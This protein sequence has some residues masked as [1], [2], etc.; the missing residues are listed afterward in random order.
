[1]F[2]RPK[3]SKAKQHA[4][5][6]LIKNYEIARYGIEKIYEKYP[7]GGLNRVDTHESFASKQK[8]DVYLTQLALIKEFRRE[9]RL[10]HLVTMAKVLDDLQGGLCG[11]LTYLTRYEIMKQ[12][13]NARVEVAQIN[14]HQLLVIGRSEKSDDNNIESWG[15]EA[16]ICDPWA[17]KLYPVSEFA[18]IQKDDNIPNYS[19]GHETE[20][21]LEEVK[22]HYLQGGKIS[23]SPEM[24][25]SP[26]Y[27]LAKNIK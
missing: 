19:I 3:K 27:D 2:F 6:A 12:F 18:N 14:K 8:E 11:E 25:D 20:L 23:I 9:Y 24:Q 13:P 26:L 15:P 5:P 1:M 16:V 21:V 10:G 22:E 17:K 7:Y 4:H